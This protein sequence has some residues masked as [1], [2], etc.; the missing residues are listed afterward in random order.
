M[1][2]FIVVALLGLSSGCR[3]P[4]KSRYELETTNVGGSVVHLCDTWTGQ[5][6]YY[7]RPENRWE[8]LT[9]LEDSGK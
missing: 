2:L 8:P 7:S 5:V 3:A 1:R 9:S 4:E 6:W